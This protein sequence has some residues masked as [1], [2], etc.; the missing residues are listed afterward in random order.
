MNQCYL[1]DVSFRLRQWVLCGAHDEIDIYLDWVRHAIAGGFHGRTARGLFFNHERE[2]RTVAAALRKYF[3]YRSTRQVYRGFVL[4]QSVIEDLEYIKP[5]ESSSYDSY[6]ENIDVACYFADPDSRI[7]RLVEAANTGGVVVSYKPKG[8]EVLFHWSWGQHFPFG[9][10]SRGD[11]QA[12]TGLDYHIADTGMQRT[13]WEEGNPCP[14]E[15]SEAVRWAIDTQQEMI[16]APKPGT[17]MEIY[18]YDCP[19]T[20]ELNSRF[21]TEEYLKPWQRPTAR[22]RRNTDSPTPPRY[23]QCGEPIWSSKR[24]L[25]FL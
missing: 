22:Y 1:D 16:V 5:W 23:C 17:Q 11:C 20:E 24:K 13:W 3:N 19:A 2:I 25:C 15:F 4:D 10:I 8:S 6:T 21:Y 18:D 9:R 14:H 7:N 12:Q